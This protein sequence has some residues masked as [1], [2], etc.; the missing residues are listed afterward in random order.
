MPSLSYLMIVSCSKL[1]ELPEGIKFLNSLQTLVLYS[2][3]LDF[4]D[5]VRTI[6]GE[7]GVDFY[8][9]AHIPSLE[10]LQTK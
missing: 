7:Q 4:C 2:M 10:I 1:E 8:K 6:N 3:P 9:V 5:K